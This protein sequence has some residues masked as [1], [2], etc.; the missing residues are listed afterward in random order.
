MRRQ[1]SG[2]SGCSDIRFGTCRERFDEAVVRRLSRPREIQ[3][4]T[5]L[6]SPDIEIAGDELRSLVDANRLGIA[7]GFA[8]ALQGQHDILA[9]IVEAGIDGRRE[10]AESV[11]D[12]EHADL[13]AGGELV[14][15]KVHRPGLVD[16]ACLRPILAQLGLHA[17]L[18]RFVGQLQAQLPVKTIDALVGSGTVARE[19]WPLW[20]QRREWRTTTSPSDLL[21]G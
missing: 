10:A 8:D 13:A 2:T 17:T 7:D 4:D 1:G 12:R 19:P 15:N 21:S 9:S 6:V 5:L 16:L 3:H 18:R 20:D 14:V 11:Y